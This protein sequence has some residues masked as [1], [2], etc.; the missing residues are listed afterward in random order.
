MATTEKKTL[1]VHEGV[2]RLTPST[3]A[4]I[5]RRSLANRPLYSEDQGQGHAFSFSIYEVAEFIAA[6]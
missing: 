5:Y 3:N 2:E 1:R 4:K 6:S